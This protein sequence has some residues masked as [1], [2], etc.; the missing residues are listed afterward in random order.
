MFRAVLNPWL[1]PWESLAPPFQLP[2]SVWAATTIAIEF[3]ARPSACPSKP[4][5]WDCRLSLRDLLLCAGLAQSPAASPND[6]RAW[7]FLVEHAASFRTEPGRLRV[8]DE[9]EQWDTRMKGLFAERCGMG[10]A[11]WLLWREF[12]VVHIA[13]A[14]PFLSEVLLDPSSP[15]HRRGLSLLGKHGEL[16][17]D[18]FCLTPAG[19]VVI[20]ESKGAVGPPSAISTSEKAKAKQQV[21]NVNPVGA[22][23]RTQEGRL[24]FATNLRKASDSAR[25]RGTD[26]GVHIEDPN[27]HDESPVRI[28]LNADRIVVHAYCK[29]LQFLGL[30]FVGFLLQRAPQPL[31]HPE[32]PTETLDGERLLV[33]AH[34]FGLR[35]GLLASVAKAVLNEPEEGIAARVAGALADS[36]LIRLSAERPGSELFLLPNGFFAIPR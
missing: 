35:F 20:A 26:T 24:V 31:L 13:D 5:P 16:R 25:G 14:G 2:Y 15:Y 29:V 22:T 4:R 7:G 27:D 30:G 28:P 36:R 23:V 19:E 3:E 8:V 18:F 6:Y 11:A 33:L 10:L 12:N 1:F 32:L 21:R 17:P 34:L 9:S